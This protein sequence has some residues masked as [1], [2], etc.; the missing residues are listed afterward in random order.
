[1]AIVRPLG[2]LAAAVLLLGGCGGSASTTSQTASGSAETGHA[3]SIKNYSFA[4][5]E[6]TVSPGTKV[7]WSNE[8]SASHTATATDGSFDTG[9]LKDGAQASATFSDPGTFTYYCQFHPFM[10]AKIVVEG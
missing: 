2:F 3:V 1:M 8:D 7:T 4:P 10:K 5:G 6:L 9:T